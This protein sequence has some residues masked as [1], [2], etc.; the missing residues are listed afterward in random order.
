[1]TSSLSELIADQWQPIETARRDG[2][3]IL[4]GYLDKSGKFA[5]RSGYYRPDIHAGRTKQPCPAWVCTMDT[6]LLDQRAT[7]WM[8]LPSPPRALDQKGSSNG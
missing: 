3:H 6:V 5:A 8:P 1:M 2:T 4:L 7:H